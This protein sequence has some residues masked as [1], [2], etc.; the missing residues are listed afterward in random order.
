MKPREFKGF[1]EIQHNF[2]KSNRISWNQQDLTQFHKIQHNCTKS[3]RIYWNPEISKDFMRSNMIL[4]KATEFYRISLNSLQISLQDLMQISLLISFMDLTAYFH[5][6]FHCRI[7]YG[8]HYKFHA[9]SNFTKTKMISWDFKW[10]HESQLDFTKSNKIL[11]NP[12][13][14]TG[15]HKIQKDFITFIRISLKSTEFHRTSLNLKGFYKFS[16]NPTQLHVKSIKFHYGFHDIF[17]YI[18]QDFTQYDEIQHNF[19]KSNRISWNQENSKDFMKFNTILLKA[20][21]FHR[22]SWNQQ[23]LTQFHKIQPNCTKSNRIYWNPEISKDFMRSNMILLRATEFYRI[24][25][26][27]LQISL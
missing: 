1:H 27:S 17:H 11:K 21:E 9:K 15:L 7:H 22:I 14:F 16:W 2:T 24:S 19:T 26:N 25:L 12:Q 6:R 10:L 20:T 8:F 5:Y 13:E 4:L 23:D 18:H 3:N